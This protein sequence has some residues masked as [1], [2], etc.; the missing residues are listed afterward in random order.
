[1]RVD[2]DFDGLTAVMQEIEGDVAGAATA[3]MKES[4][5]KALLT[6][7]RQVTS[8]GLGQRLANTWRDRV[9]PEQRRSMTPSGYIWSN[10]PDIVDSFNRGAV[11]RPMGGAK[12]LWIPTKNVPRARGRVNVRGRVIKGGAMSPEE[13]ENMFNDQLTIRRGKNGSLLAFIDVV[14]ARNGRA[15]RSVTKRRVAAGRKAEP[16]LMFVLR[17]TVALPRLLDIEGVAAQ[18]ATNFEARLS[19][20]LAAL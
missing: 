13:V 19:S 4:T 7:R 8:N 20:R 18:W 5:Y 16:V 1:M 6:L 3:A 2:V 15:V 11:I 14:R 10:A 17:R 12:Y 9:F